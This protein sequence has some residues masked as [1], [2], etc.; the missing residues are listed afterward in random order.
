MS[1][2]YTLVKGLSQLVNFQKI[3]AQPYD[4]L[5]KTFHTT[6]AVPK[7]PA[8]QEP[9]FLVET[10]TIC[11]QPVLHIQHKK[12]VE[13][14]CVYVVGGGMLK[15]PK[16]K[17]AKEQLTLAR[18]TG[19]DMYMPYYPLVPNH[20]L[21]DVYEILYQLYTT[22][23]KTYKAEDIAFLGGS[24]GGNHTLGLIS[25]INAKG[26]G[27]PMPGKIYVS[28]PG[29]MLYSEEEKQK[30]AQL[31]KTDLIMSRQALETI[32]EGM[33]A[34]REVPEYMRYLQKGNYTGLQNAYLCFGGDEV[35]S[36]AAESIKTRME[37]C[38]V[39]VTL[40]IGEGLYHC[41]SAMPLVPEAKPGYDHMI[42]YLKA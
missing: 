32:F 41:Y 39:H 7:I 34:G 16:P 10:L 38:G 36:A 8:L 28:S 17:Q 9:D 26:E 29:T 22:L 20:S 24:S 5:Q 37:Q 23:L 13:K 1:A 31:D 21:P 35:F 12:P 3:M 30:A 2:K 15:Y 40:E 14:V 33:A 4:A 42:A 6:E 27:I 11:G 25:Y 19:R 18:Q